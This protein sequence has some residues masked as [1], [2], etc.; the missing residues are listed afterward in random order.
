MGS[1]F[2]ALFVAVMIGLLIAFFW[3]TSEQLEKREEMPQRR[4]KALAALVA[5]GPIYGCNQ[6]RDAGLAPIQSFEPG[7]SSEM[8]GDGDGVAC[9][10]Y[11]HSSDYGDSDF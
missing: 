11:F 8:D 7:Y 6:F 2:E 9:E 5:K 4:E 10:P 3:G 1:I